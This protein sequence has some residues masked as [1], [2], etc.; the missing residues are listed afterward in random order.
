[1]TYKCELCNYQ[2]YDKSNFIKHNTTKKHKNKI[3]INKKNEIITKK[4]EIITK[5]KERILVKA[6]DNASNYA[7]KA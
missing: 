5:E 1:M 3:D 4:N 6:L 7:I 2:T